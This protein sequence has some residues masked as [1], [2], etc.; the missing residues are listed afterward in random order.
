[1]VKNWRP[2]SLL[3]VIYKL[4][5]ATIAERIKNVLATLVSMDQN[6]FIQGRSIGN[7]LRLIYAYI[8][9]DRTTQHKP[10]ML[11]LVDF[12]KVVEHHGMDFY[13]EKY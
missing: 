10:R 9:L 1:M 12:E 8:P 2:I 13:N 11:L 3:N 5:S 4:G 7:N 6:R